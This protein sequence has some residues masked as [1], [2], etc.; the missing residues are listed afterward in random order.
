MYSEQA[1]SGS[2]PGQLY[3]AGNPA[4]PNYYVKTPFCLLSWQLQQLCTTNVP[5]APN[6]D[7]FK[8]SQFVHANLNI[9]SSK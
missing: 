4:L 6:L 7:T 1:K 9:F 3:A 2:L 8:L 5:T